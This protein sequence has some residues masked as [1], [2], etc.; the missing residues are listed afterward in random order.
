MVLDGDGACARWSADAVRGEPVQ[1]RGESGAPAGL[2]LQA[3]RLPGRAGSGLHARQ[4]RRGSADHRRRLGAAQRQRRI[5]RADA[6]CATALAQSVNAVAARLTLQVGPARRG[7]KRRSAW[8][9]VR[10]C[11]RTPSLALGTSEVSLLE[12]TGAYDVLA[13]G[14][15][16]ARAA[17]RAPGA[18]ASRRGALRRGGPAGDRVVAPAHVA[19]MNDMLNAALASGTGKRAA[20]AATRRPARPAPPRVSATPGSSATRRSS[21][22]GVWVGNDDGRAMNQRRRRQPSGGNLARRHAGA[23]TTASRRWRFPTCAPPRGG[24]TYR[25]SRAYVRSDRI[26]RSISSRARSMRRRTA[27]DAGSLEPM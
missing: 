21:T 5:P 14:G 25:R 9:S 15:R 11:A 7:R 18:H 27:G 13:N 22:T 8:A 17:H 3:V 6:R 12:L 23:R 1:P 2:G 4:R 26:A 10:R 24:S 20:L 19:A 16:G